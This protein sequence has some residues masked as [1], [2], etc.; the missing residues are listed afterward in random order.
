LPRFACGLTTAYGVG[1][2]LAAVRLR[3]HH[4]LRGAPGRGPV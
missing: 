3:A 1:G 4:G 2:A